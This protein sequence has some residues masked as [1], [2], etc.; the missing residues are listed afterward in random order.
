RRRLFAGV[1]GNVPTGSFE[2]K[3]RQRN[4]LF[5]L[6]AA[7]LANRQGVFGNRLPFFKMAPAAKAFIFV[8]WHIPLSLSD[9]TLPVRCDILL[10]VRIGGNEKTFGVD[11]GHTSGSGGGDGLAVIRILSVAACKNAFDI[12]F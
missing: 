8:N 5:H 12:R 4:L 6:S 7:F 9:V 1:I 11:G 3:S 2:L 10:N